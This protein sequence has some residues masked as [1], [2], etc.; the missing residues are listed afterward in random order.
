MSNQVLQA[1]SD[2]RSIRG[3]KASPVTKE[4]LDT[5]LKA[6]LESPS[7]RN[8]Q[9]WHFSVVSNQ[10]I[11]REINA[12]AIKKLGRKGDLFF[13]APIVIFISTDAESRWG[14]LDSG[15]AV[16]NMA[17]AA[18]SL[19]L[20]SVILGLPE[21]AFEGPQGERFNKQLRFPEK[22]TYAVAIAIG[23]PA[24]TKDAHP[25]EPDRIDYIN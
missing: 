18:H 25:I 14:R 21:A 3:Y 19:G 17:L 13:A 16:E 20:G 5:V 23:V 2:R 6:A 4:Q 8:A 9:P 10:D 24:T 11:I 15:I 7:A 22:H 1:I 12:E